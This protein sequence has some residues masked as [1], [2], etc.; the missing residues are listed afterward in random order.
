V[1]PQSDEV[2]SVIKIISPAAESEPECRTTVAEFIRW[3][4]MIIQGSP[5]FEQD[6][7]TFISLHKSLK[8]SRRLLDRFSLQQL[9]TMLFSLARPQLAAKTFVGAIDRVLGTI[10]YQLK[11]LMK[12]AGRQ[13]NMAKDFAA[14]TAY[15]LIEQ[16]SNRPPTRLEPFYKLAA[17]LHEIYTGEIDADLER[18]CRKVITQRGRLLN[19]EKPLRIVRYVVLED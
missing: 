19:R 14:F 8:S 6:R 16:F 9:E 3:N 17:T 5:R 15:D 12:K 4:R 10:E 18:Q 7:R 2:N 13:P 1:D 11:F